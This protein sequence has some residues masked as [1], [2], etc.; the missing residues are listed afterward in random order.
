[1]RSRRC[2]NSRLIRYGRPLVSQIKGVSDMFDLMLITVIEQD[3]NDIKA[4]RGVVLP[5]SAKPGEG[6]L[7]DLSLFEG[8]D[9]QLRDAVSQVFT[10]LDLDKDQSLPIFGDDVDLAPLAAEVPFDNPQAASLQKSGCKFFA[11]IADPGVLM[12]FSPGSGGGGLAGVA[13]CPSHAS[14]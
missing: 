7:A 5:V 2:L 12:T 4:G 6:G 10:A 11:A 8:G 9:C 13:I 3:C 1:M 14:T